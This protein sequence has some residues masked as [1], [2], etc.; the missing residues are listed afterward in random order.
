MSDSSFNAIIVRDSRI[1]DVSTKIDY[2]VSKGAAQSNY[3]HIRSTSAGVTNVNFAVTVPSE[4]ILVDRNVTISARPTF[5]VTIPA[6][7]AAN[8]IAFQY[9]STEALNQFPLNS[10]FTNATATINQ[11]SFSVNTQDMLHTLIRMSDD[12]V[13]S[14]YNC[15][16]MSDK[17]FRSYSDMSLLESNPL[18]SFEKSKGS[19]VP[20]G[21]HPI[22]FSIIV[23]R[24]GAAAS[25]AVTHANSAAQILA[26]LTSAHVGD[27]WVI[28]I[29]FQST[30]P[31]LFLSPFLTGEWS[32]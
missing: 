17:G 8:S 13:L 1:N 30:E 23:T 6:G 24:N 18:G 25:A 29:S 12:E 28:D 31:L 14:K 2:I 9:G 16:Y 11:A 21:S 20:R 3:Q 26:A 4:N 15:P 5:R 22:E 10:L 19:V 7:L 32:S 27:S